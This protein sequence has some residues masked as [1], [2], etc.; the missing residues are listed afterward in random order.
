[1]ADYFAATV[2]NAPCILLLLLRFA[3]ALAPSFDNFWLTHDGALTTTILIICS[4]HAN[5]SMDYS[6]LLLLRLLLQL[7]S[8]TADCLLRLLICSCFQLHDERMTS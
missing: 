2:P 4:S 5:C 3:L 8:S 6:L 7:F 1:M